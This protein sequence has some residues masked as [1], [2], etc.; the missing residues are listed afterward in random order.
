MRPPHDTLLLVVGLTVL[1]LACQTPPAVSR[2]AV[3]TP[4]PAAEAREALARR[5]WATAA[6]LFRQAL[7][8]DAR[9]VTLHYGLAVCATYLGLPDE[10]TREFR[11]VLQHAPTFS[12]EAKI[13]GG[14]LKESDAAVGQAAPE[15]STAEAGVVSGVVLWGQGSEPRRGRVRQLVVLQGIPGTTTEDRFYRART[16]EHG[17][18]EFT[19]IAPG[20]YK[21]TDAIAGRATWRVKVVVEAGQPT[22]LDL[23][24]DNAV[25]RRDDFPAPTA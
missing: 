22:V 5:D 8:R 19:G 16:D 18:Y 14:W 10:A 20:P 23:T 12:E 15:D 2:M 13:A 6:P 4:E 3:V 24:P 1:T 9:D 25:E 11:W 7:A 17:R 21:L